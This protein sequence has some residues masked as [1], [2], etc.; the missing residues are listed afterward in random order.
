MRRPRRRHK[1]ATF[2]VALFI[3][4][5]ALAAQPDE[6]LADPTLEARARAISR[7]LRCVVCQSESID[8]SNAPLARD[9]RMLVRERISAGDSDAAVRAYIVERYGDYVLLKPPV[10]ANTLVLWLTPLLLFVI[11]ALFAAI[12]LRR[13]AIAPTPP[14]PLTPEEQTRL[15]ELG[16]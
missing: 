7:E 15:R 14:R 6:I 10:Q 16:E 3:G 1:L 4:G 5:A 9:L 13:S 8:D 2:L 12:Q 11:A